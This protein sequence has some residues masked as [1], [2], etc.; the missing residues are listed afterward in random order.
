MTEK[1]RMRILQEKIRDTEK[2]LE[3]DIQKRE[4]QRK[5]G[6]DSDCNDPGDPC[7]FQSCIQLKFA[8]QG[9]IYVFSITNKYLILII[10]V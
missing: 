1:E 5:K 4:I 8:N 7:K 9:K 2:I 6:R 3:R 10:V